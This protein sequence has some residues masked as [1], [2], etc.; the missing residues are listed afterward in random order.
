MLKRYKDLLDS[1]IKEF[2]AKDN[3][4]GSKLPQPKGR[5]VAQI[6][7]ENL[8]TDFMDALIESRQSSRKIYAGEAPMQ[9]RNKVDPAKID[10]I[11][12]NR[13]AM[14]FMNGVLNS[15]NPSAQQLS[16]ALH[17]GRQIMDQL[18]ANTDLLQKALIRFTTDQ[19]K[20]VYENILKV[21]EV[22]KRVEEK[23]IYH[24][25]SDEEK[26]LYTIDQELDALKNK[27]AVLVAEEGLEFVEEKINNLQQSDLSLKS[28]TISP[29]ARK[30]SEEVKTKL[31]FLKEL[32]DI[33]NNDPNRE[34]TS[35]RKLRLETHQKMLKWV[36]G[37]TFIVKKDIPGLRGVK[38][39]DAIP[40]PET[41]KKD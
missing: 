10:F 29:L 14:Y 20:E 25:M 27:F 9:K 26:K 12:L 39:S 23:F 15:K 33:Y 30:L 37:A 32:F 21:V 2:K 24:Q 11:A 35:E 40:S 5:G 16:E 36:E 19:Q 34:S 4:L 13:N 22:I 38:K 18:H 41:P 28:K 8:V 6:V 7:K 3:Q 31:A 1:N 17:Y